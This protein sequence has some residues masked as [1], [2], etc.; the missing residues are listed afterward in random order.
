[1]VSD[2]VASRGYGRLLVVADDE[3]VGE[4]GALAGEHIALAGLIVLQ[5]VIDR[6]G[7][8]M[9]CDRLGLSGDHHGLTAGGDEILGAFLGPFRRSRRPCGQLLQ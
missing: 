4:R 1:M 9:H 6:Q 5:R 8:Q 3:P 7:D 2:M